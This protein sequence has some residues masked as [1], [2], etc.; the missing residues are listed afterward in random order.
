MRLV[1]MGSPLEVIAPL[2]SLIKHCQQ[3]G[4]QLVAVVSQPAKP[5]GRKQALTDPPLA[6]FAKERG[7]LCLQ[8]T[9]AS[10]PQFLEELKALD[11]D[12]IITAAY[13][14]ILSNA[15][16]AIPKRATIN[17]HPSLLPAYRGAIPVPAAL[18]D[19]LDTTGVTVLFT[20]KALDA[21]N[22]ILQESFAI[23]PSETA[24]ALTPRLFAASAPLLFAALDKL[25][26]PDFSGLVQDE[27][28]VTLCRK[29]AKTDGA[30]DW[31]KAS[32]TILSEFRAYQPWPGSYTERDKLRITVEDMLPIAMDVS[33]EGE[34]LALS[35]GAFYFDKKEKA[36]RV[37]TGD[38]QVTIKRLKSAGSK[39][40]DAPAFWNGLR[41]QGQ[42]QFEILC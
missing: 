4:D 41:L 8:P 34:A 36:I 10:D 17:I 9:K 13:G 42:G 7:L 16:L 30:I 1:F 22:I 19:G 26:D 35:P 2:E 14:Q 11:V 31:N 23:A 25:R 24:A 20:V 12:V 28:K 33:A 3:S 39:S 15:F 5:A 6:S 27:S 21:G 37:G 40:V 29:I 18:L 32:K 38:G